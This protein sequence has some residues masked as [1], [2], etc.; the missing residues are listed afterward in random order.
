[1]SRI[2]FYFVLGLFCALLVAV[3]AAQ[4]PEPV[5]IGFLF[6]SFSGVPK[7]LVILSSTAVG[8][9]LVLFLGFAGQFRRYLHI[10]RLEQE[11]ESL[12]K[13]LAAARR[14]IEQAPPK[15][16]AEGQESAGG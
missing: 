9:L 14:A 5:E 2:Q 11:I 8:A 12:K 10:R 3:F 1:M 4:N 6:W 7:V 13:E 16:P 15:E